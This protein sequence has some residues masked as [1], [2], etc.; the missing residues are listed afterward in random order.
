MLQIEIL[1]APL[2]EARVVGRRLASAGALHRRVEGDRIC[3]L[4]RA[5]AH[6]HWG[7]IAAAAEPAFARHHH[8]RVHMRGWGVW[9]R[10][11][12]DEGDAARPEARVLV[13]ARDLLGEFRREGAIDGRG[14]TAD[15]L[16]YAAAHQRHCP[17][18]AV[19]AVMIL[20]GPGRLG[21]AARLLALAARKAVGSVLDCFEA[22]ADQ[23][24]Q[25][26]EPRSSAR[27]AGRA[28]GEGWLGLFRGLLVHD[29]HSSKLA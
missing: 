24:L 18:A 16:E 10:R 1:V 26:L 27:L 4:L 2:L 20:A 22:R 23:P 7:E 9:V 6:Q 14:V 17:A 11:M 13:G 21:E 25:L 8:A 29:C 3:V 5:A 15:L 12:G 28:D 19:I